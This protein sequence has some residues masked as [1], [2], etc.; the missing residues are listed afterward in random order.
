MELQGFS[1]KFE[2]TDN[3]KSQALADFAAEWSEMAFDDPEEETS[4]S[5]KEVP[6]TWTM[7]FDG[8]YTKGQGGAR[9]VL[10]SP[11]GDRLKYV[12]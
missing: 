3:I 1:L 2:H 11:T 9:V 4:L 6:D 7:H 5:G 8:S 12:V 10:T